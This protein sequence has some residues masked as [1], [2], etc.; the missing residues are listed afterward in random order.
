MISDDEEEILQIDNDTKVLKLKQEGDNNLEAKNT[1]SNDEIKQMKHDI[2]STQDNESSIPKKKAKV[3]LDIWDAKSDNNFNTI[4]DVDKNIANMKLEEIC[5]MLYKLKGNDGFNCRLIVNGDIALSLYR[6]GG[7]KGD[8][9]NVL[10]KD[11]KMSVNKEENK[12]KQQIQDKSYLI[13]DAFNAYHRWKDKQP[14]LVQE[15]VTGLCEICRSNKGEFLIWDR[16][17]G[18]NYCETC[19]NKNLKQNKKEIIIKERIINT[20]E[21]GNIKA[22]LGPLHISRKLKKVEGFCGLCKRHSVIRPIAYHK[23]FVNFDGEHIKHLDNK[24]C[25]P[26]WED[27]V[28]KDNISVKEQE[29]HIVAWKHKLNWMVI[30]LYE[31]K[32]TTVENRCWLILETFRGGLKPGQDSV[33]TFN[34]F[35]QDSKESGIYWKEARFDIVIDFGLIG[36]ILEHH[37]VYNKQLLNVATKYWNDNKFNDCFRL[38]FQMDDYYN[39]N[40]NNLHGISKFLRLLER[41]YLRHFKGYNDDLKLLSNQLLIDMIYEKKYRLWLIN[42]RGPRPIRSSRFGR[43]ILLKA[44]YDRGITENTREVCEWLAFRKSTL[45]GDDWSWIRD[46]AKEILNKL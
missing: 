6:S 42:P 36:A 33:C 38:A 13:D 16:P 27:K 41:Y 43:K 3:R 26:C 45:K 23:K 11:L 39:Y 28:A 10:T 31:G 46:Y 35:Y 22:N 25:L 4:I 34:I 2:Q 15:G 20:S 21:H 8:L 44:L 30:D 29:M 32:S 14:K 18:T 40:C 19:K 24:M 9:S 37:D 7:L 17:C 12:E 5:Q 1:Y